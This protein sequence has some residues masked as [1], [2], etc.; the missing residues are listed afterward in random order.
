M[1]NNYKVVVCIP[2]GRERYLRILVPYLLKRG[3]I[4]D[5][6]DFWVNTDVEADIK[7]IE[8][9]KVLDPRIN[10]LYTDE[11]VK[12][13]NARAAQ[14]QYND[15]VCKFYG[16]CVD[17]NSIYFKIDD[18]IAYIHEN[19]F[20]NMCRERLANPN[21]FFIL[22]NMLNCPLTSKIYQDARVVDVAAGMCSGD[23]RCAVG[24]FSG[25]FAKHLH[26]TFLTLADHDVI[27]KL[28]FKS[29]DVA[30]QHLRIGSLCFFGKDF[31]TFNGFVPGADEVFLSKDIPLK[32]GKNNRYCGDGL[33]CHFAFS[34]QRTVLE[35]T[36]L[37]ERY[38]D[39]SQKICK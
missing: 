1:Y 36:N 33:V 17:A 3:Q 21:A 6:F 37:L 19:F 15:S 38:Y 5:R 12:G 24:F 29:F 26:E 10:L 39:Y 14:W 22:A 23:N 8:G 35:T 30:A 13:Y 27:D 32:L 11:V 9:L 31:A 25:A 4:V 28:F 2:A 18:D 16:N 34:H 7:Y 20:E